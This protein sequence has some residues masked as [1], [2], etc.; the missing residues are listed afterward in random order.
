MEQEYDCFIQEEECFY[1]DLSLF[2]KH[3]TFESLCFEVKFRI[4]EKRLFRTSLHQSSCDD[5]NL[6]EIY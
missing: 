1:Y 2:L 5:D 6:L 3:E 4:E